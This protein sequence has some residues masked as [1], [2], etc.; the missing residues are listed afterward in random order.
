MSLIEQISTALTHSAD[1]VVIPVPGIGPGNEAGAPSVTFDNGI[2]WLV[3]RLRHPTDDGRGYANVLAR[4]ED[5][6]HFQTVG[7]I[8][9]DDFG[10]ASLG[11]P[12]LVRTDTGWRLYVS[13]ATPHSSHWWVAAI[14]A[15]RPADLPQGRRTVVLAGNPDAAWKDPV[16]HYRD[17]VWQ[18]W[19]CKHLLDMGDDYADRMQSWY[20]TSQDGLVWEPIGPVLLPTA[21]TWDRRGVRIT[22]VLRDGA[23]WIAHYDGRAGAA[24]D[25][26]ERTGVA[27]GTKPSEMGALGVPLERRGR[28]FR[29]LSIAEL[30]GRLHLFYEAG[31]ADGSHDVR[32][33]VLPR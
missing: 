18:M 19:A 15:D 20:F 25:R 28:P 3:H 33:Q 24:E 2:F 11:R 1:S 4:S 14:D 32:T 6:L 30:P 27:L 21:A 23:K 8:S 12:A 9:A 26:H 13:C 29:Y 5:G 16:V 7:T 10:A 17:G 31:N 22:N